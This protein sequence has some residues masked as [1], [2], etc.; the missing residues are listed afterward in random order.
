[1]VDI[2]HVENPINIFIFIDFIL[3][4]Y[5]TLKLLNSL[6]WNSVLV[7]ISYADALV[8]KLNLQA[9]CIYN[10]NSILIMSEQF[11]E[12]DFFLIITHLL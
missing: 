10:T 12:Y 8:L 7:R 11:H 4:Q 3:R 6:R 5:L 9:I 1:M 2:V